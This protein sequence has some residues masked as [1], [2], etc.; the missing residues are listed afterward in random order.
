MT[1]LSL[2]ILT[3]T[4]EFDILENS[5]TW[6]SENYRGI[7]KIQHFHRGKLNYVIC[8]GEVENSNFFSGEW[9]YRPDFL[10][11]TLWGG[12]SWGTETGCLSAFLGILSIHFLYQQ[13]HIERKTS[14][15]NLFYSSE[16]F[17]VIFKV[18]KQIQ[19]V[20]WLL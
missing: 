11:G 5:S 10:R 16:R 17:D 13:N 9:F 20:E 3:L 2:L 19:Y 15:E 6:S 18:L 7:S 12:F 1:H 8:I 14:D 4:I